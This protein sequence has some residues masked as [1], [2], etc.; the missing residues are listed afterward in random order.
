MSRSL[1]TTAKAAI[2]GSDTG[3]VFLLLLTISHASL[4]ASLRFVNNYTD[5]VSNGNT[6][7]AFPFEITLPDDKE[8][9]LPQMRLAIDNVD[10]Q[11]VNAIRSLTSPPTVTLDVILASAPNTLEAS[12]SGFVL[13]NVTYGELV[14]EGAL[15]LEDVLNESFPQHSFTPNTAPGL[16]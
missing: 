9:S 16:F 5:I 11:I 1:S 8:E 7:T 10:R 15:L 4:S 13:R 3:Q 14:V 12:F 6:Y 2:F